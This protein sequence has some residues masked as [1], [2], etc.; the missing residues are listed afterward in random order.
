M[1]LG[2][3][4]CSTCGAA[5][6]GA[7]GP[8]VKCKYCGA[9]LTVDEDPGLRRGLTRAT[10]SE[11]TRAPVTI[12]FVNAKG[13]ALELFWLDFAGA[14]QGYGRIEVSQAKVFDT[15]V[16]HVWSLRDAGSAVEVLRWAAQD[17]VPRHVTIR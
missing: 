13:V 4:K 14:E 5:V 3:R 2:S 10:R 6:L 15:F 17:Q 8:L 9:A 12:T 11:D 16:G 1:E 7:D